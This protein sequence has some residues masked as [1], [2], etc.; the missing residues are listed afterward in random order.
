MMIRLTFSIIVFCLGTIFAA[1]QDSL[2]PQLR[3]SF[4]E[5]SSSSPIV[6]HAT[7]T[8][9]L[10]K[11]FVDAMPDKWNAEIKDSGFDLSTIITLVESLRVDDSI[12]NESERYRLSITKK[13][14]T[15]PSDAPGYL[16]IHS[17]KVRLPVPL[18]VTSVAV[19][20]IQL[21]FREFKNKQAELTALVEE[22]KKSPKG[23]VYDMHD[24]Y[25]GSWLRLSLE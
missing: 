10:A 23:M 19:G 14:I 16:I 1:A 24:D 25:D 13:N 2:T 21:A 8:V 4:E 7:M 6:S 15:P 3:V 18:V 12:K 22:I 9:S 20:A 11:A 17:N 5:I